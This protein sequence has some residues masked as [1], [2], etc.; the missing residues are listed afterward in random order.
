MPDSRIQKL[1]RVLCEYSLGL[2][3]GDLFMLQSSDVA[4]PL[5]REV[6]YESLLAGAYPY[7]KISLEGV[8][9]LPTKTLRTISLDTSA[10]SRSWKWRR[11][12]PP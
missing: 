3:P 10:T 11:S 9:D 5:V 4:A 8:A 1:A 6:F 7:L 2:R 12:T